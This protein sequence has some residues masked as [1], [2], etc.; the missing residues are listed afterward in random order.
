MTQPGLAFA[1]ALTLL[2]L[3]AAALELGVQAR[4]ARPLQGPFSVQAAPGFAVQAL[5]PV[6][7]A[8]ALVANFDQAT[9]FENGYYVSA[10]SLDLRWR[11]HLGAGPAWRPWAE[12]GIGFNPMAWHYSNWPGW[13]TL[14]VAGGLSWRPERG[15]AWDLALGVQA[16]GPPEQGLLQLTLGL[17]PRWTWGSF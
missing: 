8:S 11:R 3:P 1:C 4:A 13:T 7:P 14:A 9:Y 10:R 15:P 17:G 12:A 16:W 5:L 6:G 2:T